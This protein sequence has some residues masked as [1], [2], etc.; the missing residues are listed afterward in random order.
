MTCVMA[1]SKS[2][3][4]VSRQIVEVLGQ[5]EI[6][7]LAALLA[8]YG[9]HYSSAHASPSEPC[10]DLTARLERSRSLRLERTLA[11]DVPSLGVT[12][13]E[14]HTGASSQSNRLRYEDTVRSA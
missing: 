8:Q 11:N 14:D 10:S 6:A 13:V 9:L 2:A 3:S 7:V 12:R 1:H 5:V 4:R